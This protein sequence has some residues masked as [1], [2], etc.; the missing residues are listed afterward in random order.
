MH[1]A[2]DFFLAFRFFLAQR[3]ETATTTLVARASCGDAAF[4]PV[5]FTL[6]HLVEAAAF[7]GLLGLDLFHPILE[8][9]ETG[10]EAAHL[11]MFQPEAALRHA[12]QERPVVA[13][14]QGGGPAGTDLGLEGFNGQDVQVVGR[15]VQ[16]NDIRVLGER[17]GQRRTPGLAARQALRGF[18]WID[19]ES[20]QRRLGQIVCRPA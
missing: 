8:P 19:A 10:V 5:L 1:G 3:D 6:Q 15:L 12:F 20:I 13:D 9:G 4:H 16:Q 2:P 18:R 17:L 7:L 14:D 11:T